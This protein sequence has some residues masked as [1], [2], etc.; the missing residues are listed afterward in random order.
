MAVHRAHGLSTTTSADGLKVSGLSTAPRVGS[1]GRGG[2]PTRSCT[3]LDPDDQVVDL[4][5]DLAALAHERG[6]LDH[7]VHHGGVVPAA[8]FLGDSGVGVVGQVPEQVHADLPGD[9]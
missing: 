1:T 6:D 8:E 2:F 3:S 4:V 7:G 9:D 5:E